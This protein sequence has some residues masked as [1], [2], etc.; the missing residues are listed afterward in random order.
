[1]TEE[2]EC[3]VLRLSSPVEEH[4]NRGT[5]AKVKALIQW[6]PNEKTDEDSECKWLQ[7]ILRN[8]NQINP[9]NQQD[10]SRRDNTPQ[11]FKN[12]KIPEKMDFNETP[13][14]PTSLSSSN[15]Y[16]PVVYSS[17]RVTSA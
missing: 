8:P 10:R 11:P 15:T 7:H 3:V 2:K 5:T 17:Y 14:D 13:I 12:T 9:R 4:W 6:Y 1:M 16:T